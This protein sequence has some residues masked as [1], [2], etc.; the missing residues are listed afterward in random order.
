MTQIT[1]QPSLVI[2]DR[3]G[4]IN[5]DSDQYIKTAD[6]WQPIP[7]SINAIGRLKAKKFHLLLRQIN[8]GLQ[9][10]ILAMVH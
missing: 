1:S 3:D 6:E 2:L 10:G 8:Q 9:E 5:E 7:G 4:V